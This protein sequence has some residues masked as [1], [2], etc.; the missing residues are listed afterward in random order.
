M[1][2]KKSQ[3]KTFS[4]P[5]L[6]QTFKGSVSKAKVKTTSTTLRPKVTPRLQSNKVSLKSNVNTDRFTVKVLLVSQH[7]VLE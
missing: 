1:S 6:A 5:Q 7:Q 3:A 2:N 4:I